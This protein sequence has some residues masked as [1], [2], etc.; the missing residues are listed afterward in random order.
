MMEP[1]IVPPCPRCGNT[2]EF[3]R[4][5]DAVMCLVCQLVRPVMR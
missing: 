3:T 4:L 5:R 2:T 1:L